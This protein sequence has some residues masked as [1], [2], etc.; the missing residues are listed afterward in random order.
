MKHAIAI[1]TVT[2]AL[3]FSGQGDVAGQAYREVDAETSELVQKSYPELFTGGWVIIFS[4]TGTCLP[5]RVYSPVVASAAKTHNVRKFKPIEHALLASYFDV[6]AIPTTIIFVEG[7]VTSTKRGAQSAK[8]LEAMTGFDKCKKDI[9]DDDK[10]RGPRLWP[11]RGI[12][13]DAFWRRKVPTRTILYGHG[14]GHE[15]ASRRR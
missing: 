11:W 4:D 3:V 9:P 14:T 1:L 13:P 6:K 7:K 2:L 12:L 15:R 10:T 8:E 5:C